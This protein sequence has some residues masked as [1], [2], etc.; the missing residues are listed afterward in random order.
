MAST[1]ESALQRIQVGVLGISL[2]LLFLT[3]ANLLYDN[4]TP[5]TL[6]DLG[7][8]VEVPVEGAAAPQDEPLAELG[9]APKEDAEAKAAPKAAPMD[10][11][12]PNTAPVD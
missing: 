11:D 10:L 5:P 2:V 8:N 4:S 1:R 12:G 9:V 6:D 3:V 7:Q